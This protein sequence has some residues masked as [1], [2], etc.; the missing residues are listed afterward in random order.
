M[1]Q[2]LLVHKNLTELV[3]DAK[4]Y[5]HLFYTIQRNILLAVCLLFEEGNLP[6]EESPLGSR[7]IRTHFGPYTVDVQKFHIDK[8]DDEYETESFNYETDIRFKETH[9]RVGIFVRDTELPNGIPHK[10][11]YCT[12]W[13]LTSPWLSRYLDQISFDD[14]DEYTCDNAFETKHVYLLADILDELHL[15]CEVNEI[16]EYMY[17][18]QNGYSF[19][20][21]KNLMIESAHLYTE[22]LNIQDSIGKIKFE[23]DYDISQ[24]LIDALGHDIEDE[25]GYPL[26]KYKPIFEDDD[27]VDMEIPF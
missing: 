10:M 26:V 16:D 12:E 7:Y 21:L 23:T 4:H 13:S 17:C 20:N 11:M 5:E 2:K 24:D 1:K 8:R 9:D 6:N 15:Y 19:I 27:D 25:K 22:F 14:D 3:T 18:N